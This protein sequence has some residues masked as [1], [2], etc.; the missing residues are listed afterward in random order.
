MR[1]AEHNVNPRVIGV[2][3]QGSSSFNLSL[4]TVSRASEHLAVPNLSP[5]KIS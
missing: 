1:A 4:R 2:Q 5:V 3:L